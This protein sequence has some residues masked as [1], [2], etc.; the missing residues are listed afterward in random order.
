MNKNNTIIIENFTKFFN[1]DKVGDKTNT[2]TDNTEI[3]NT[4]IDNTETKNE[5]QEIKLISNK[6]EPA[7]NDNASVSRYLVIVV[8]QYYKNEDK[9]I[10][11]V[12]NVFETDASEFILTKTYSENPNTKFGVNHYITVESGKTFQSR[13]NPYTKSE[14]NNTSISFIDNFKFNT[15]KNFNAILPTAMENQCIVFYEYD[16]NNEHTNWYYTKGIL[17]AYGN[18]V[19][20]TKEIYKY[21]E[22]HKNNPYNKIKE[23]ILNKVFLTSQVNAK[24]NTKP[25]TKLVTN[26]KTNVKS[27]TNTLP[28]TVTKTATENE[29]DRLYINAIKPNNLNIILQNNKDKI[30]WITSIARYLYVNITPRNDIDSSKIHLY[31]ELYK[32]IDA[33][34]NE[35]GTNYTHI[36]TELFKEHSQYSN[37]SINNN[38]KINL[39]VDQYNKLSQ[40]I[41]YDYPSFCMHYR[42][43][44]NFKKYLS[45]KYKDNKTL[46]DLCNEFAYSTSI[47]ADLINQVM[48]QVNKQ[49]KQIYTYLKLTNFEQEQDKNQVES[50]YDPPYNQRYN[51]YTNNTNNYIILKHLNTYKPLYSYDNNK[52]QTIKNVTVP[53]I[54]V[55]DNKPYGERNALTFNKGGQIIDIKYDDSLLCGGFNKVFSPKLSN[56]NIANNIDEIIKTLQLPTG[57]NVFIMGYGA[58]GSGKT[59]SLIYF[60]K[61]QEDGILMHICNKMGSAGWTN[62]EVECKEY[63]RP[64]YSNDD[65]GEQSISDFIIKNSNTFSFEYDNGMNKFKLTEKTTYNTHHTYR[66]G[67]DIKDFEKN[68]KMGEIIEYLIDT[69]RLV[70]ATTNNPNSSRSHVL[71]FIKFSKGETNEK[72]KHKPVLIIGDLAG[73]ENRFTCN[74]SNVLQKFYNVRRD[75]GSNSK[76]Y[77]REIKTIGSSQKFDVIYGGSI[78]D[79]QESLISDTLPLNQDSIITVD[80]DDFEPINAVDNF[81]NLFNNPYFTFN[82]PE[83][84]KNLYS[85]SEL[86]QY[87]LSSTPHLSAFNYINYFFKQVGLDLNTLNKYIINNPEY[88][89]TKISK[90]ESTYNEEEEIEST[91]NEEETNNIF[92]QITDK[93]ELT[94]L[95]CKILYGYGNFKKLFTNTINDF[96]NEKSLTNKPKTN[97]GKTKEITFEEYQLKYY[98]NPSNINS[99]FQSI[100]NKTETRNIII[101]NLL[102]YISKVILGDYNF[103]NTQLS[104]IIEKIKE[105]IGYTKYIKKA[106]EH[107]V[108][109]G[110]YINDSLKKL[111]DDLTNIMAYKNRE[112]LYYIPQFNTNCFNQYCNNPSNCFNVPNV[113]TLEL[114]SNIMMDINDYLTKNKTNV[115]EQTN[116][117]KTQMQEMGKDNYPIDPGNFDH[118]TI[119]I[120]GVFN[121]SRIANN[122]PPVPYVNI[123]KLKHLIY[124]RDQYNFSVSTFKAELT[125]V[126]NLLIVRKTS[127][128]ALYVLQRIEKLIGD[129]TQ[130]DSTTISNIIYYLTLIHN[131]NMLS[132]VGTVEFLDQIAKLNTTNSTCVIDNIKDFNPV[133]SK[134]KSI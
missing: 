26:T 97:V 78:D 81:E 74:N 80:D 102:I 67:V 109:E 1:E 9:I 21:D 124:D 16:F 55:K 93:D 132:A 54:I 49:P 108:I 61:K 24:T 65:S 45:S 128:Y 119:C 107:R 57:N 64:Y 48:A 22:N 34:Y 17:Y 75:D 104:L 47:D 134:N 62:A 122:P 95:F 40:D 6:S 71:C 96:N 94:Y 59:S 106:C 72:N 51:I 120:F 86:L 87:I 38:K 129:K 121:W 127:S 29:I 126:I 5:I 130:I 63:F 118:L 111:T 28:V 36:N 27:V 20:S 33:Y 12:A 8:H 91:Y 43:F 84:I 90:L 76:F 23:I 73:V 30:K 50:N 79:S 68:D 110:E 92:D 100:K 101:F 39:Y 10:S 4:E 52:L 32:Y 77:S 58:S 112:N 44:E 133:Y 125:K 46:I 53:E 131:Q 115:I 37:N 31:H 117:Q 83:S 69:D 42:D 113:D 82:S 13:A 19:A 18:G 7:S 116:E 2:V 85:N 66:T 88:V 123:N 11:N 3:Y 89:T 25:D 98:I 41:K 70:K 114:K 99:I 14:E 60:K 35:I 15:Y 103:I 105:C 56:E